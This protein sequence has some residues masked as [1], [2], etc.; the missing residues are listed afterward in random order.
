LLT[1]IHTVMCSSSFRRPPCGMSWWSYRSTPK[2]DM[3]WLICIW[4]FAMQ[5]T[6]ESVPV[7]AKFSSHRF[8]SLF[9]WYPHLSLLYLASAR[10]KGR[11]KKENAVWTFG[12]KNKQHS[13]WAA[14]QVRCK[15]KSFS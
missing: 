12:R 11:R 3:C 14:S 15:W 4:G 13:E 1:E 10:K 7:V 2:R 8:H 5:C 6:R 9:S